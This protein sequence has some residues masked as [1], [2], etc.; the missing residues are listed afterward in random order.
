MYIPDEDIQNYPFGRLQKV[1]ETF[2]RST[3]EP[4]PTNPNSIQVPKVV[5]PTNKKALLYDIGD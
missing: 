3:N 1:V 2:E 5:K 4:Q